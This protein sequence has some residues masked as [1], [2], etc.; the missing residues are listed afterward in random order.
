MSLNDVDEYVVCALSYNL[1]YIPLR[2]HEEA[3]LLQ[4][5]FTL[6]S[7]TPYPHLPTTRFSTTQMLRCNVCQRLNKH[8]A[9]IQTFRPL[10]SCPTFLLRL[11]DDFLI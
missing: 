4:T 2:V 11:M 3:L 9:S 6:T 10:D 5:P 1:L 7:L 8:L